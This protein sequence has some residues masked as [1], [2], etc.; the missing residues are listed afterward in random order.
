MFTREGDT[1]DVWRRAR[2]ARTSPRP[3]TAKPDFRQRRAIGLA[4]QSVLSASQDDRGA[5]VPW[6]AISPPDSVRALRLVH[7][8]LL[9]A[10]ASA[11]EAYLFDVFS[12]RLKQTISF[13]SLC[14]APVE[15]NYV[16]L[17]S[18]H[19]FVCTMHD[20]LVY[21]L[22]ANNSQTSIKFPSEVEDFHEL[23]ET[24]AFRVNYDTRIP[25]P[26]DIGNRSTLVEC[27]LDRSIQ[28]SL[29]PHE[30]GFQAGMLSLI[31]GRRNVSPSTYPVHVSP[32]G[33]H[34]VAVDEQGCL[35]IVRNFEK[36][37][38]DNVSLRDNITILD[39][40][41]SIMNLAFEDDNRIVIYV[42]VSHL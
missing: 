13:Q 28:R 17:G 42:H 5:F 23:Y 14:D 21:P 38:R 22:D 33:S 30:R 35:I 40:R 8:T 4:Y 24:R 15:V 3:L 6:T 12:G 29:P 9:V 11:Q 25:V 32:C 7:S 19:I 10:S 18:R 27:S 20:V 31:S 26:L 1:L 37:L 34:F 41:R 36:A 16:E 39:M 2:D